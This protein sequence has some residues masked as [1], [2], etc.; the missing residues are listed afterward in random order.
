MTTVSK[1]KQQQ[2]QD[3]NKMDQDYE[4][5]L[6]DLEEDPELRQNI[7]LYK[8]S[9]TTTTITTTTTTIT[10]TSMDI[11]N[12]TEENDDD[13]PEVGIEELLEDLT[14]EDRSASQE[15]DN[16]KLFLEVAYPRQ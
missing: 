15:F 2:K 10:T 13:F 11:D 6:Q 16:L 3:V 5:F 9:T 1:K 14:L 8:T 12:V 7:N 4:M